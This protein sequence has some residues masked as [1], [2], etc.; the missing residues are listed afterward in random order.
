MSADVNYEYS[1]N[2]LVP[3]PGTG[4]AE[5]GRRTHPVLA[6]MSR[7]LLARAEVQGLSTARYRLGKY[8]LREPDYRQI[9]DW[10][11]ALGKAPEWVLEQLEQLE[12]SKLEPEED[13]DLNPIVFA[14][15]DG[16]IQSL[17]WDFERL[18]VVPEP[19]RDGLL[20]HTLG[21][22]GTWPKPD[23]AWRPD[24]LYLKRVH[25]RDVGL[26][27]IDL[28]AVPRLTSLNCAVNKLTKVDLTQVPELTNLDCSGNALTALDLTPV[29]GLTMLYCWDNQL[30]DLDLIPVPGLTTLYCGDNALTDLDLTPVPGLTDLYC[31]GNPLTDLDLTPVPGLTHLACGGNQLTDL[32][33]T[34]VPGL[35][36][37][38][39]QSN[40][41]TDLDLTPV[42]GLTDLICDD[43]PLTDLDLTPV[44]GLTELRC[45]GNQ[46]TELDLS[47]VPALIYLSCDKSVRLINPPANLKV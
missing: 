27:R 44:P 20:I 18:P 8:V 40:Q 21:L 45:G 4:L 5:T 41:L 38:Y 36:T 11:E 23:S 15:E 24:L 19:W 13:D 33:L 39:C 14:A 16:D 29:L 46:L 1:S 28:S 10:A 25:C 22:K 47:S 7:D 31:G 35:A 43:N 30:T 2:A 26:S 32:D 9:L 37:L 42:P 12:E 34:L 17:V 6:R 3:R